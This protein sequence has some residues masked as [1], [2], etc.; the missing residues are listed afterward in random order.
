MGT[1]P[2]HL[3]ITLE[4]Q[5]ESVNLAEEMC[6]RVAELRVLAKTIAIR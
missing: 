4:T 1:D 3:E 5:V 6:I 2:K